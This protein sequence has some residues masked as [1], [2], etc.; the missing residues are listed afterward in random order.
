[1]VSVSG[2]EIGPGIRLL[3]P[4]DGGRPILFHQTLQGDW[5]ETV[6]GV[7]SLKGSFASGDLISPKP[8]E[9]S[10]GHMAGVVIG[11]HWNGLAIQEGK[12]DG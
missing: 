5:C 2:V 3:V 9:C 4:E 7:R 11:G 12:I 6:L 10:G 1:M 8:I